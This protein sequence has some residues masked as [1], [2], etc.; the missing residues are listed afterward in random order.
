MESLK[1]GKIFYFISYMKI[2]LKDT[3]I[4]LITTTNNEY[5]TGWV[6]LLNG[7]NPIDG[8]T[9]TLTSAVD[10]AVQRF[11]SKP[12]AEAKKK[13]ILDKVYKDCGNRIV[14]V[15]FDGNNIM[16]KPSASR[17]PSLLLCG[18]QS[19]PQRLLSGNSASKLLSSL[20]GL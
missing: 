5:T 7:D 11:E 16:G 15:C 12:W 10:E 9:E 20:P 3:T 18:L 6:R 2:L 8:I 4:G 13:S 19:N 1:I 14:C 17:S